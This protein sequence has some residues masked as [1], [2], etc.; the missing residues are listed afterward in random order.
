MVD[1]EPGCLIYG[2]GCHGSE[3]S[4]ALCGQGALGEN[5]DFIAWLALGRQEQEAA[6]GTA[7]SFLCS[8]PPSLVGAALSAP[9]CARPAALT[10][11]P[12]PHS[13]ALTW[14]PHPSASLSQTVG[15][16]LPPSE[17]MALSMQC[18]RGWH[19]CGAPS[20]VVPFPPGSW[21]QSPGCQNSPN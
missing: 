7:V 8:D 1:V 19:R 2:H 21:T 11:Q 13:V 5:P 16:V 12:S 4:P 9:S 10:P 17:P 14:K 20:A 18:L 15:W 6:P 3:R